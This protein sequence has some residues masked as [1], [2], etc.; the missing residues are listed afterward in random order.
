MLDQSK[1]WNV[2]SEMLN[3]IINNLIC[4][5]VCWYKI[6]PDQTPKMDI[7]WLTIWSIDILSGFSLAFLCS[8]QFKNKIKRIQTSLC[9][10]FLI[11]GNVI[12]IKANTFSQNYNMLTPIKIWI[13][14]NVCSKIRKVITSSTSGP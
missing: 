2:K 7:P 10:A 5:N 12:M 14:N 8:N 1:K 11:S 4:Q 9:F 13:W 6:F 3:F